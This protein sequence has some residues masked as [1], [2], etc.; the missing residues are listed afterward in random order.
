MAK[1]PAAENSK[2]SF[3]TIPWWKAIQ[4]LFTLSLF[5]SIELLE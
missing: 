3:V 1:Y 4:F 2:V 5:S